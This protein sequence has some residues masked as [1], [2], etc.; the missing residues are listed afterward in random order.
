MNGNGIFT[1]EITGATETTDTLEIRVQFAHAV[2]KKLSRKKTLRIVSP[3]CRCLRELSVLCG[4]K[5][6][7]RTNE[8]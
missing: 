1:T 7:A 8:I 3:G 5:I 2:I 4:K 6:N